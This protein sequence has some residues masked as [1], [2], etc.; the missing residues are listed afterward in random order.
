[1][2]RNLS[3][4]KVNVQSQP[5]A[6]TWVHHK[7]YGRVRVADLFP[8]RN[9]CVSN[10]HIYVFFCSVCLFMCLV[11][12]V[13][14]LSILTQRIKQFSGFTGKDFSVLHRGCKTSYRPCYPPK[15][16]VASRF[17]SVIYNSAC[18]PLLILFVY[19]IKIK[20]ALQNITVAK[21]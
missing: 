8:L 3:N 5:F 21:V 11:P 18:D 20:Y 13:S 19:V 15:V 4:I 6:S 17:F 10:D 16:I 1:M 2:N 12:N 7:N 9:V 14:R